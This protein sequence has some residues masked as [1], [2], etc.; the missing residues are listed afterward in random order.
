[1]V[2]RI[3]TGNCRGFSLGSVLSMPCRVYPEIK[4]RYDVLFISI[5]P[6]LALL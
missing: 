6:L 1:M 4:G 3:L 2:R 5:L